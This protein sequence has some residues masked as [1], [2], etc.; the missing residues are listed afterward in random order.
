M[1]YVN[2][3]KT[4]TPPRMSSWPECS[5]IDT[6]SPFIWILRTVAHLMM[7][8]YLEGW[9]RLFW[10]CTNLSEMRAKLDILSMLGLAPNLFFSL[11]HNYCQGES[12]F[13]FLSI[14]CIPPML[15]KEFR[16]LFQWTYFLIFSGNLYK[17]R[18][19]F[20]NRE[21]KNIHTFC[22]HLLRIQ[23]FAG[24]QIC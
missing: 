13:F 11:L 10:L 23:T 8:V 19:L 2:P 12:N 20:D 22:W 16:Q 9:V 24:P 4:T 18:R 14:Y 17:S 5:T 7:S 1:F 6:Y 3:S 21:L 15:G